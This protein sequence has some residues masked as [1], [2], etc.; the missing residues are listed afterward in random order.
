MTALADLA[1]DAPVPEPLKVL[2][3]GEDLLVEAEDAAI[4]VTFEAWG[5]P[6]RDGGTLSGTAGEDLSGHRAVRHD[7]SGLLVH[8][9]FA[10]AAGALVAGVTTGAA[11]EGAPAA[12]QCSGDLGE[13]SWDWAEGCIFLG[14]AGHLTQVAPATGYL[15]LVGYSAGPNRMVVAPRIIAQLT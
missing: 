3:T 11:L 7:A 2:V 12:V 10:S 8:A 13:P 4:A 6:G 5:M 1:V 15:V 14:D 9:D